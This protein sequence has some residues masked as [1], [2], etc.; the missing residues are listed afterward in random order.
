[1]LVQT[2]PDRVEFKYKLSDIKTIFGNN[3][4]VLSDIKP[5]FSNGTVMSEI[6]LIN[7]AT[8][9]K[10]SEWQKELNGFVEDINRKKETASS[11]CDYINN[12]CVDIMGKGPFPSISEVLYKHEIVAK[13]DLARTFL[14]S[15]QIWQVYLY[16]GS[17]FKKACKYSKYLQDKEYYT[18]EIEEINPVRNR[19]LIQPKEK[20]RQLI[21]EWPKAHQMS[22][23]QRD[24]LV[25]YAKLLEFEHKNHNMGKAQI[26]VIDEIFDYLDDVNILLFQ[27]RISNLIDKYRKRKGLLFPILVTHLDPNYFHHFC[28]NEQQIN[29]CY[30]KEYNARMNLE[31]MQ[32]ISKRDCPDL[33]DKLDEAYFHFNP[34]YVDYDL[35]KEFSQHKLNN[36]WATPAKFRKAIF[37]KLRTYLY[38][39]EE[40]YDPIAVC[41]SLRL[42]IEEIVYS[43]IEDETQK[44]VFVKTH[45]T[46]EKLLYA[47]R[48]GVY[49]KDVYFLLGLIYNVSLHGNCRN[50][51]QPTALKLES[52]VIKN[53]I[54]DIT[55]E[56]YNR[57]GPQ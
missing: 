37:R 23:G 12:N 15:W 13:T 26:L 19:F 27:Y 46:K 53:M 43:L 40:P 41:W 17:D 21:V 1:V 44:E 56:H 57:F 25:F 4:K 34:K 6:A 2:V 9:A 50:L 5:V 10:D 30:L 48:I 35:T 29:V 47:S 32:I 22:N 52:L 45:K 20:N 55:I 38:E 16:L 14:Y 18:H 11:L 3:C 28:F 54:I 51:T 24:I 49:I 36:E 42:M 31:I 39:T 8:I 33:K 7:L